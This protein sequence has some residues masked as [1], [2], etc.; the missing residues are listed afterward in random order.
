[1]SSNDQTENN[2]E[3]KAN[4]DNKSKMSK[5]ELFKQGEKL[6]KEL[7]S[8]KKDKIDKKVIIEEIEKLGENSKEY[9][10][11]TWRKE[12]EGISDENETLY[13]NQISK[14]I[15]NYYKLSAELGHNEATWQVG[16]C[17]DEGKGVIMDK[18]KAKKYYILAEREKEY[19]FNN[20]KKEFKR[21]KDYNYRSNRNSII[22]MA[23]CLFSIALGV[24]LLI[25]KSDIEGIV[26]TAVIGSGS[27]VTLVG[28][29][30]SLKTLFKDNKEDITQ[31]VNTLAGIPNETDINEKIVTKF[32]FDLDELRKK[33]ESNPLCFMEN[34]NRH[35]QYMLI[36]RTILVSLVSLV[37]IILT[38]VA[39]S[40]VASNHNKKIKDDDIF[41]NM[42]ITLI[43]FSVFSLWCTIC[44]GICL[45]ILIPKMIEQNN[46][47]LSSLKYEKDIK[48]G[49]IL[50]KNRISNKI[51]LIIFLVTFFIIGLVKLKLSFGQIK[52][53]GISMREEELEEINRILFGLPI[54]TVR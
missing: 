44:V 38:V 35:M 24:V 34:L 49:D 8:D 31:A 9:N 6:K 1:M 32:H 2:D 16:C 54:I 42:I 39:I 30:A 7:A 37:S 11:E 22:A 23:I 21:W 28:S 25:K 40:V 53:K 48:L 46:S 13:E 3:N 20:L 51:L 5:D 43:S 17:Y 29:L 52:I 33:K 15:F 50:K 14:V 27:T 4:T 18:K 19:Y 45:Q 47:S 36:C 10:V 12:V 26:S 41:S